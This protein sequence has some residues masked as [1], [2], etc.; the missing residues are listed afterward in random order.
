MKRWTLLVTAAALL[1]AAWWHWPAAAQRAAQPGSAEEM[2]TFDQYRDFRMHDVQQ[3]QARL[4]GYTTSGTR[5][6]SANS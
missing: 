2:I 3:R 5:Y 1:A 4:R 6:T